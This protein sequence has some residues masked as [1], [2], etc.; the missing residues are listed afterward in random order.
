MLLHFSTMRLEEKYFLLEFMYSEIPSEAKY[1]NGKDTVP[2]GLSCLVMNEWLY[3][4]FDYKDRNSKH[5]CSRC[6]IEKCSRI[7]NDGTGYI[8]LIGSGGIHK[9]SILI[10]YLFEEEITL[11]DNNTY[12]LIC[13][14]CFIFKISLINKHFLVQRIVRIKRFV[15]HFFS[16]SSNLFLFINII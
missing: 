13:F 5:F 4:I 10:N 3:C 2:T 6:L 16:E 14:K 11:K 15:F 7:K 9:N 1:I 8:S 12:Y